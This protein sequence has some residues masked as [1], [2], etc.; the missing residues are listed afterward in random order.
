MELS[1]E[2]KVSV[3][4]SC[5]VMML[6]PS[7]IYYKRHRRDDLPLRRR[8]REIAQTRIRYGHDRIYILFRREGWQDNHKR[9]H[10]VYKEEGL[11]LRSKRPRRSKSAAHRLERPL[12]TALYQSWPMDFV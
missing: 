4:K 10:R 5:R 7:N 11:N 8:I 1:R 12:V 2:Y 9:T 3:R 6:H